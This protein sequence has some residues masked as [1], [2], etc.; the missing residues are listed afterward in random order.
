MNLKFSLHFQ[1][2]IIER[3]INIDY[4]KKTIKNPDAVRVSFAGRMV[5]RKA[6]G[7]KMLEVVYV[8]GVTPDTR[9][10]YR[11]ITAY[12]ILDK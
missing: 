9:N 4:L 11:I 2:A 6:V 5:A 8:K 3:G 10:E 12:Y 7:G 1:Q